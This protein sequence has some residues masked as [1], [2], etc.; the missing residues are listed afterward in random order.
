MASFNYKR[1]IQI[2][3]TV[4]LIIYVCYSA[5]IFSAEGRAQFK[6]LLADVNWTFIW[7]SLLVTIVQNLI[8]IRKWH[9]VVIA[10]K[11]IGS[12]WLLLKYLYVSRL[13]NLILPTSMGGD[14]IRIYRLG[15][16]NDSLERA[17]ASVF[18]ERFAGM[19]VLLILAAVSFAFMAQADTKLFALSF[20]FV[21][22]VTLSLGWAASDSRFVKLLKY[23]SKQTNI[24]FILKIAEKFEEFQNSIREVSKDKSFL[25]RLLG[26][27]VIFYI[28]AV[29]SVWVSALA[30]EQDVSIIHM[31]IAVPVI[32]LIMNL[33][34]SI[35]GLGLME[36]SY[37]VSFELLGYSAELGLI[38]ALIM[39]AKALLDG[40]VGGVFELGTSSD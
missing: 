15:K 22:L 26:Y 38:T 9:I 25:L 37:T 6:N 14:V 18:V 34:V 27:S 36:A 23:A 21:L 29:L 39:R 31:I 40:L 7:L 17:A 1:L 30:F 24:S 12:F 4:L 3:I 2:V 13:Y 35:G 33:P 28:L 19:L 20:L 16:V 32:M 8:S 11:M 5:G 10:K